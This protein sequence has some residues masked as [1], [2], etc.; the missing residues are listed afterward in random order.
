MEKD[1]KNFMLRSAELVKSTVHAFL[2]NRDEDDCSLDAYLDDDVVVIGIQRH[3]I[4]RQLQSIITGHAGTIS[5]DGRAELDIIDEWYKPQKVSADVCCVYGSV[6]V[7]EKDAASRPDALD[8]ETRFSVVCRKTAD[9]IRI[10]NIHESAALPFALPNQKDLQDSSRELARRAEIDFLTGLYNRMALVTRI[11]EALSQTRHGLAALFIIDIDDFK[12]VNDMY[13]HVCGD[14]VLQQ[15]AARLGSVFRRGDLKGRLGGDEFMAYVGGMRDEQTAQRRAEQ[16]CRAVSQICVGEIKA[17]AISCTVGI[18]LIPPHGTN[19]QELYEKADIALYTAKSRGKNQYAVYDGEMS[20]D[21]SAA[22]PKSMA[23]SR[24]AKKRAR[25]IWRATLGLVAA[26]VLAGGFSAFC[27]GYY[28]KMRDLTQDDI[29]GRL[30]TFS[31]QIASNING[32]IDNRFSAVREIGHHYPY[33]S[34]KSTAVLMATF[35]KEMERWGFSDVMLKDANGTWLH[36]DASESRIDDS[37]FMQDVTQG[38]DAL[39]DTY[40][41]DGKR[42]I[43]FSTPMFDV[44]VG[45]RKFDA[46]AAAF[47]LNSWDSLVRTDAFGGQASLYIV[48][49]GGEYVIRG[50]GLDTHE[51]MLAALET[52]Q[53]EKDYSIQQLREQ[54]ESGSAGFTAYKDAC[55]QIMLQSHTPLGLLDWNLVCVVP[56]QAANFAANA[57]LATTLSACLT[58]AGIFAAAL[59]AFYLLQLNTQ[60]KLQFAAYVDTVTGGD[61]QKSFEKRAQALLEH[62]EHNVLVYANIRQ[63]KMFNERLGR[64]EADGILRRVYMTM[65][66]MLDENECCARLMADHFLLLLRMDTK[67]PLHVRLDRLAMVCSMLENTAGEPYEIQV[68]FGICRACEGEKNIT[69]LADK[70]HLALKSIPD[71]KTVYEWYQH[72]MLL[73]F[74]E[75]KRLADAI[76]GALQRLE[77]EVWLQPL[78]RLSDKSV[79]GA[80]ALVRWMS[81]GGAI[82]PREFMPAAEKSGY[83]CEIDRFVFRKICAMCGRWHERGLEKMSIS[84]NLSRAQLESP[85]FPSTYR[86][87]IEQFGVPAAWLSFELHETMLCEDIKTAQ[88]A[89][90]EIHELGCKCTIDDFGNGYSSL[91]VLS[92]L[93]ADCVKLDKTFFTQTGGRDDWEENAQRRGEVV[94]AVLGLASKLGMETVAQGVEDEQTA[95]KLLDMGCD[96]VQGFAYHKPMTVDAFEKLIFNKND[97]TQNQQ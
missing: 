86:H 40:Q 92:S 84:F 9:G 20:R 36:S 45:E 87:A 73:K 8:M 14:K 74:Q 55:G 23:V 18:A 27:Y 95:K 3:A 69:A 15:V 75:E 5:L 62:G 32:D 72:G 4:C 58:M 6:W 54:M 82:F 38:R 68:R 66:D 7:R 10:V 25:P 28:G 19:F 42:C 96:S 1:N 52:A 53:F 83:I 61:N 13:G 78:V 63:F 60:K 97:S 91:S 43:L 35:R 57:L 70:A 50:D 80:E 29:S 34:F 11:T 51:N 12:Q 39:S 89:I 31:E 26:L 30:Q 22:H 94:E 76:P 93:N 33:M 59:L 79:S 2:E 88:I 90:R 49:S 85:D 24:S 65:H 21:A 37:A 44:T 67:A 41:I 17:G 16:L 64:E 81:P 77:F 48:T 56:E 47:A 46:A 71:G